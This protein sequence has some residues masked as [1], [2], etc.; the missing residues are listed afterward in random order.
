ME[1]SL[2][3]R[4]LRASLASRGDPSRQLADFRSGIFLQPLPRTS[5]QKIP[6]SPAA[7]SSSYSSRSNQTR[8]C[9]SS[10]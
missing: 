7:R 1:S 10:A 2:R 4:I 8:R 6:N 3:P 5:P 9:F